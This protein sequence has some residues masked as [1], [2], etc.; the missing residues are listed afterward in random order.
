M[1]LSSGSAWQVFIFQG[2]M[3]SAVS[4]GAGRVVQMVCLAAVSPLQF[5]VNYWASLSYSTNCL[6]RQLAE[7]D[8]RAVCSFD[9]T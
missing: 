2:S 1:N 4:Q 5:L 9:T 3:P 6:I 8:A 7:C